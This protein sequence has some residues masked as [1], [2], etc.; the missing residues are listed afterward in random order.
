[1]LLTVERKQALNDDKCKNEKEEKIKTTLKSRYF[2]M[3]FTIIE[4]TEYGVNRV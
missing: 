1:M 3:I 4:Q 2:N